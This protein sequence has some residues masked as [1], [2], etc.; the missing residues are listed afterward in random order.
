MKTALTSLVGCR[1]PI[2]QTGMGYVAGARLAAAT[3]QAGGLGVIGA[4]TMSVAEMTEAIRRVKERTDAPFGVNIRSDADDAA[5]RIEVMAREGVRVASFAQAPRRDLIAR[6]KDA[7]VVTIPSVGARRHAEKVAEWGVDAVIVQGGEGGGHTGP[8]ATTLLLPQV[9]DAV[10]I[11]VIAAGG[12]FDGRGL[13]AA[14]AYGASGIAMGT[15][16][17]LT[18]DSPVPDEV[19]KFYLAARETVVTTK[20]DGVPHRVLTTPFVASLERSRLARAVLNGARFKRLSGLSWAAMIREGRRMRRARDLTWAQVLQ[21]ANTPV[22]LRAAM[23]EG[24]VDLGVMAS[25]QVVGVI[26][27]LPSCRELIDRVMAEATATLTRLAER[28]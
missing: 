15:R 18:S 22:L 26:D 7:G 23:V 25:G 17:L 11:P 9:V 6:L 28:E 3:S 21:A 13:V 2:V 5:E 16:F 4:A 19:K 10:D 27:D 8:V 20:V 1:Y 14:L 12:F 24:R